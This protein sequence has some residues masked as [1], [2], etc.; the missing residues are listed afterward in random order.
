MAVAQR[1]KQVVKVVK[2]LVN[3]IANVMALRA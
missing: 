2:K 1:L 3:T